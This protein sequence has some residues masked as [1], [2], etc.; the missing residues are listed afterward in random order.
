MQERHVRAFPHSRQRDIRGEARLMR[1]LPH[2]LDC[3]LRPIDRVEI[4]VDQ[5]FTHPGC[6]KTFELRYDLLC[7]TSIQYDFRLGSTRDPLM[8]AP[9]GESPE[10]CTHRFRGASSM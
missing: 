8:L 5:H 4:P 3:P 1:C 10:S 6:S 2:E 9:S 7:R